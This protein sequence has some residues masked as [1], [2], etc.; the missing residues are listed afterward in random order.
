MKLFLF[1][2][3]VMLAY[4]SHAQR[5]DVRNGM[6]FTDGKPYSLIDR[7]NCGVLGK[8]RITLSATDGRTAVLINLDPTNFGGHTYAV[9]HFLKS[10]VKARVEDFSSKENKV[11]KFI[12]KNNLFTGGELNEAAVAEFVKKYP[13]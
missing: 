10:N 7:D 1:L 6:V 4:S 2:I 5:V 8:C 12:V 11:A 13:N 3:T 9:L